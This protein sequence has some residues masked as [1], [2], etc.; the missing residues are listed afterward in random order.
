MRVGHRL[1]QAVM[2]AEVDEQ[3]PAVI[4]HA[5]HPARQADGL[6]N[7]FFAKLAAS[8]AAIKVHGSV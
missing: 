4:A 3:Q 7:V 2:V 1:G 8:M 6:A 5:M